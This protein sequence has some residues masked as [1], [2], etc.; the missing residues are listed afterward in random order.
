MPEQQIEA[1]WYIFWRQ[2]IPGEKNGL[3]VAGSA[4][5][6]WW[7]FV[8]DWDG[9]ARRKLGLHAGVAEAN[10]QMATPEGETF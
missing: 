3:D 9:A 4:L 5:T 2:N 1:N 8:G 7:E 6:N 10:A